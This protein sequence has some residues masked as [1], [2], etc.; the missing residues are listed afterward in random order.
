MQDNELRPRSSIKILVVDDSQVIHK[1]IQKILEIEGYSV[2][3]TAVNGEQAVEMYTQHKPDI[4]TMDINMPVMDGAEATR[5]IKTME[6]D[7]KIIFLSSAVDK[8]TVEMANELGVKYLVEKP[9][10][11]DKLLE[12]IKAC[13]EGRTQNFDIETIKKKEVNNIILPFFNALGD[14]LNF[15]LD[16]KGKIEVMDE[17]KNLLEKGGY[18]AV[19][20]F[21]G[22]VNGWFIMNMSAD[23]AW[24][25]AERV[26]KET[27]KNKNDL[28]I[29][30]SIEELANIVCGNAVTTINNTQ[31]NMNLRVT[32]P[33]LFRGS[34]V[35]LHFYSNDAYQGVMK[36]ELGDINVDIVLE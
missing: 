12:A 33:G 1:L 2:C 6:P 7:A 9:F 35:S 3:G 5:Q 24:K 20:G 21:T 18:S 4:V 36:T 19:I 11:K 29:G 34:S 25:V 14:V 16:A 10:E 8:N 26:N 23:T 15:T 27:Y 32:P 17:K 22:K 30:Y 13:I 31:R 28:F